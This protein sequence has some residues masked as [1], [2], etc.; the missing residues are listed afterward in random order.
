VAGRGHCVKHSPTGKPHTVIK[1]L[2]SSGR[3]TLEDG[4]PARGRL[5]RSL[6]HQHQHGQAG[7]GGAW[8]VRPQTAHNGAHYAPPAADRGTFAATRGR[9]ARGGAGGTCAAVPASTSSSLAPH[10]RTRAHATHA[11]DPAPL[12]A[13]AHISYV[14]PQKICT[15]P[16]GASWFFLTPTGGC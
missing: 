4:K 10:A 5:R 3:C 11:T 14:I 13:G 8:T 15:I 6:E 1:P 2:S 12:C 7:H 9:Q 16:V